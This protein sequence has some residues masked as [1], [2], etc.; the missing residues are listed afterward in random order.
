MAVSADHI[1]PELQELDRLI[2]TGE[3]NQNDPCWQGKV[4]LF[5]ARRVRF[6]MERDTMTVAM[7]DQRR[8]TCPGASLFSNPAE[9]LKSEALKQGFGMIGWII[10][11]GL[12]AWKA[13]G[14]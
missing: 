11:V 12:L 10:L 4:L 7:C 8:A 9:T 6:M 14:Q 2:E 5:M 13:Y 1:T 3:M